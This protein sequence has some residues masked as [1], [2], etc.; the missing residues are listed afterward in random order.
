MDSTLFAKRTPG[1]G[2]KDWEGQPDMARMRAY[3]LGRVQAELKRLG[4]AAAV[5]FDPINIR[6]ASGSRNM[7]VWT[8]HNPARYLFVPAHGRCV[9]F[10]YHG[11]EHLSDGLETIAEVRKARSVFFFS[12]GNRMGERATLWA[13]E[14]AD[15]LREKIGEERRIA[16]DKL[17]PT[18]LR[19]LEALGYEVGDA[20]EPC[21]LARSVKSPDEIACMLQALSVCE[22]GIYKMQEWLKP[23]LSEIELWAQFDETNTRLGGE[24]LECR[25]L[26]S[27]GRTNPWFHEANDRLIRAGDL[28]AFDTDQIGPFGYCADIS[29]TLHCGPGRP[30]PAQRELYTLACEQIAYNLELVKPGVNVFEFAER[31]W[32]IPQRFVEQRYSCLAHGVGL[33]DEWPSFPHREDIALGRGYDATMVPGM[34]LCVESY[35]GEVG[36]G[37]GVK[38]EQQVLVTENGYQLLSTFPLE[39]RL[40]T[41]G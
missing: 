17:D 30:T 9:L 16:F 40:L 22:A 12:G 27:G 26:A 4:Y 7:A 35:I 11:C 31:S 3:R 10:D 34:T 14:L 28:V 36:G 6:Y 33:C 20:Q 37:E 1:F 21:E 25:L 41:A 8:L 32:R 18:P 23:G 2:L 15:L 24:W 29:R 39:E 5:L 38:L 13:K 19:A